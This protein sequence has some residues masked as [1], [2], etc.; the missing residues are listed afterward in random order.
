VLFLLGT[1]RL[2]TAQK[3]RRGTCRA[4]FE[5]EALSCCVSLDGFG[6]RNSD[7]RSQWYAVSVRRYQ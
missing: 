3:R 5:N 6:G 1:Y 2:F 4:T 7:T